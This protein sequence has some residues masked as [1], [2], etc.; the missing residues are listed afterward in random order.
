MADVRPRILLVEDERAL[1]TLITRCLEQAGFR[2]VQARDGDEGLEFAMGE[3]P[4]LVLLDVMLPGRSGIEVCRELRRL[5]FLPPI[6]ILTARSTVEDR[7]T[8]LEAGADDYLAKPFDDRELLARVAALLRRRERLEEA[9]KLLEL[10]DVRVD[11]QERTATVAGAPVALTKTEFALLELLAKNPG[12]PVS[13]K[14]ILDVVWSY[15]RTPDTRTVDTHIWRLR[16]KL[17]DRGI[18]P[19]VIR[20]IAGQGYALATHDQSE[21]I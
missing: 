8:G 16:K 2:V 19:R 18:T 6:L 15:A 10:G 9:P 20:H 17:G 4:D 5:H 7:V 3:A 14:T 21:Q 13:R 11:F 1:R 12:R